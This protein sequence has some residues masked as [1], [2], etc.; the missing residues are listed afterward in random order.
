MFYFFPNYFASKSSNLKQSIL[1]VRVDPINTS[2]TLHP[3]VKSI[4]CRT[5]HLQIRSHFLTCDRPLFV[6]FT[7]VLPCFKSSIICLSVL[8]KHLYLLPPF[9]LLSR[10]N[11]PSIHLFLFSPTVYLSPSLTPLL[12]IPL[13][14]FHSTSMAI[15]LSLYTPLSLHLYLFIFLSLSLSLSTSLSISLSLCRSFSLCSAGQPRTP[16]VL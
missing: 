2:V 5:S 1:W 13:S 12:S 11:F 4:S 16:L 7:F 6:L 9:S 14:N 3:I 15:P 10:I 8:L